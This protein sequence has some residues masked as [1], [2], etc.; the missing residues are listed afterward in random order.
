M[1]K[2]VIAMERQERVAHVLEVLLNTQHHGFPVVDEI[3][4]P[5]GGINDDE[6]YPR[7]GHLKGLILRSQLITLLKQRVS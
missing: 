7:Y 6:K 2:D 3:G 4:A 5:D 1:R